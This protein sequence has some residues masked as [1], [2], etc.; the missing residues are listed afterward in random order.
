MEDN[1]L[2]AKGPVSEYPDQ[3]EGGNGP[4]GGSGL[5]PPELPLT[6]DPHADWQQTHTEDQRVGVIC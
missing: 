1:P 2:L 3:Q 6:V 5:H 4:V